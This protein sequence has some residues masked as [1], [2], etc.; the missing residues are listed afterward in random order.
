MVRTKQPAL[1]IL[2]APRQPGEV[3]EARVRGSLDSEGALALGAWL[4]EQTSRGEREIRVDLSGVDFVASSGVGCLVA[5]TSEL[6]DEGGDLILI[7]VGSSL[8]EIL[9]VLD[10]LDYLNLQQTA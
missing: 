1:N 2:V 5:A 8:H 3:L 9:T 10:L 7:N 4:D 6:R